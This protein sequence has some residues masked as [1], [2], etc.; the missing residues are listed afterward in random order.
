VLSL[1]STASRM[2]RL[3][4]S[5][6]AGLPLLTVDE[7]LE[8]VDAV[9]LDDVRDLAAEFYAPATLSVGA[10]GPDEDAFRAALEPVSPALV[11]A[12]G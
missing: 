5:V 7:V 1:E 2:N 9:T 10:V 12:A 6:L 11:G 8:R 4:S 3:G